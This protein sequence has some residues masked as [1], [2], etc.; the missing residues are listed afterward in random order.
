MAV[1]T[2]QRIS[3]PE[4]D[5]DE[6]A[7]R[8]SPRGGTEPKLS[9]RR[10]DFSDI[11]RIGL[12]SHRLASKSNGNTVSRNNEEG[13]CCSELSPVMM[14]RAVWIADQL[15]VS[16]EPNIVLERSQEVLNLIYA[17][18]KLLC[19]HIKLIIPPE[20]EQDFFKVVVDELIGIGSPESRLNDDQRKMERCH[21]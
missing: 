13:Q 19:R 5:V 9:G 15:R 2:I 8:V 16:L 3:L 11:E 21:T 14:E 1:S 4:Q 6:G 7:H 17:R 12:A 20:I 18:Y 10:L